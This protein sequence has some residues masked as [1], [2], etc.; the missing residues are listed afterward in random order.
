VPGRREDGQVLSGGGA[1]GAAHTGILKELERLRV[2][3]DYVAGTSMGAI[4]GGLYSSGMTPD[5]ID[6]R[7]LV[8]GGVTN[9][10]PVD[11]VRRM[12][13]DVA[14][15]VDI[16]TPLA[17]REELDSVFAILVQLT[18]LLTRRTTEAQLETL[19]GSDVLI[20]PE[21]GDLATSDFT[22]AAE[23]I[24]LGVAAARDKQD[25]LRRLALSDA[26]FARHM[27]RREARE[28]QAPIVEFVRLDNDSQVADEVI[29]SRLQLQTGEPLNITELEEDLAAVY[30]LDVFESVTYGVVEDDGR[31]GVEVQVRE[32]PWSPNCLQFGLRYSSD[33][34]DENRLALRLGYLHLPMNR[35]NGE[36][37]FIA[38]L[39]DEPTFVGD[40]YQP[41][42]VGSA[43]YVRPRAFYT[44]RLFNT[45]EDGQVI[46][47]NRVKELGGKPGAGEGVRHL[48]SIG[49]RDLPLD[50]RR[51]SASRRGGGPGG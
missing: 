31:T 42:G 40:L 15:V 17:P 45:L 38:E 28:L 21:L 1:R 3:V 43:Y 11:V 41:L 18:G 50:R 49:A 46:A 36:L 12:G 8:D 22:K 33:F 9:N 37:Q 26:E 29:R 34:G 23:G 30:G 51:E 47:E 32:K 48:G 24:G 16:S 39:G 10:L 13:A 2:P 6:G 7:L 19:S 27:A 5:E 14:I 35:L 44:S 4:V 20:V 25:V